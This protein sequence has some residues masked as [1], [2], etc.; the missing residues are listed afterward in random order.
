[1]LKTIKKCQTIAQ[2][3][4][5]LSSTL[6]CKLPDKSYAEGLTSRYCYMSKKRALKQTS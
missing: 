3:T 4:Q 5:I 1:M 6:I 2:L